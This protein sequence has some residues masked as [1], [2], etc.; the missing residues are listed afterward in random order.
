MKNRNTRV[1]TRSQ[2]SLRHAIRSAAAGAGLLLVLAGTAFGQ[3]GAVG[4][5]GGEAFYY[6]YFDQRIPMRLDEARLAITDLSGA[7]EEAVRQF[8]EGY[9]IEAG[10]ITP[11]GA[12]NTYHVALPSWAVADAIM[13]Q[14]LVATM[15][16]EARQMF[17]DNGGADLFVSPVFLLPLGDAHITEGLIVG[18][19]EGVSREQAEQ[20]VAEYLDAMLIEADFAGMP[21]VHRFATPSR[22]G[23]ELLDV[24]NKLA[25]RPETVYAEPG[26]QLPL[27]KGV[28]PND[29]LFGSQWGLRNTGQS[30]GT[31]NMD[32]DA[33]LAW[34]TTAGFASVIVAVLDDGVE[35][36]H[37]DINGPGGSCDNHGTAVAG[38]VSAIFNN[39]V[40]VAGTAP[41]VRTVS[42]KFSSSV[43]PCTGSGTYSPVGFSNGLSSAVG[44][45]ARIS[46]NSNSMSP[47]STVTN[48]YTSTRNGGMVHFA[49]TGNDNA[50][51]VAYPANLAT[52]MGVG[53]VNRNGIRANFSNYGDGINF[54]APGVAIWTTD[55]TGAAGY[56]NGSYTSI[57]G[58][59]F[60]TPIAAGVAALVVSANPTLTPAQVETILAENAKDRGTAGFDQF[61]GWGIPD[62]DNSVAAALATL[63]SPGNINLATPAD[64]LANVD[65]AVERT[66]A[67]TTTAGVSYYRF[68]IDDDSDFS[69]PI[70]SLDL[71]TNIN[72]IDLSSLSTGMRYYW[73]ARAYN[74]AG[75]GECMPAYRSFTTLGYVEP[76]ECQGDLTGDGVVN[77]DDLG[78][79]LSSFGPSTGGDLNGDGV[80]NADDLGI[81]LALLGTTCN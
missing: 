30:G 52:V 71:P 64:G 34:D 28:I 8:A 11:Q 14:Q 40:G 3:H 66:F 44:K 19:A 61:Y 32:V 10:A 53:A 24:A 58:T 60:A 68:Q 20:I 63:T 22:N 16:S 15:A 80:T 75:N 59:S 23:F 65:P 2:S 55:R 56:V 51:S 69:S 50:N 49:S 5:A 79:L 27:R 1:R 13:S 76:V 62:A 9:G 78:V 7:G 73:R 12:P 4:P 72:T 37:P 48:I 33:D 17:T 77:A 43:P 81:L 29:P 41:G 21:G 26:M 18:F 25:A 74:L 42:V 54:A 45:G 57:D 35:Q 47:S 46:S 67:W 38:C 36:T 70:I 39:G 31:A 6:S